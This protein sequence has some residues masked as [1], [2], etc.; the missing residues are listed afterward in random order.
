M[1]H[2]VASS[3]I[4]THAVLGWEEEEEEQEGR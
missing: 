4:A 1:A 3:T 2:S